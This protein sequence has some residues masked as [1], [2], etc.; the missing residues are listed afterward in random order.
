VNVVAADTP[1]E[2]RQQ[3]QGIRRIRAVRLYG[4]QVGG[5]EQD[6]SDEQADQRLAAGAAAQVD[7]M[8]TYTAAGTPGE[9]SDYLE[10]FQQ[11][12]GADELITPHHAPPSRAGCGR[13]PCWPRRCRPSTA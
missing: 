1:E 11:R 6:V 13:S 5:R 9:V 4:R 10:G 2:A 7:Q 12:T 3:L 8:L